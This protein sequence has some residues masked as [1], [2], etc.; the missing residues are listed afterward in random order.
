MLRFRRPELLLAFMAGLALFA[1]WETILG[2]QARN[3]SYQQEYQAK[4]NP[5]DGHA[6]AANKGGDGGEEHGHKT[7]SEPFVCGVAGIPT[8][9]R[10]FMNRNEG[11]F[12]ASFTLALVLVTAWLVWA[13]LKLWDAGENQLRFLRQSAAVQAR[14]MQASISA[15]EAG[16]S[17]AQDTAQRQLRAYVTVSG[18]ARTKDPGKLEGPGFAVLVDVQN[19]GQTPAY[20]LFQWADIEIREFPLKGPLRIYCSN[21]PTLGILAPHRKTMSFPSFKRSLTPLEE[22]DILSEGKAVYVY[23]EIAY[24]DAFGRKHLTQFRFRCTGQ[25]YALG[26]FKADGQGNNAT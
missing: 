12:V 5:I 2:Y 22:Q 6:P 9:A 25:G 14:D 23:G 13:T 21:T 15:A 8:A 10:Q 1:L 7:V 11:F 19:D 4:A 24:R 17:V 26:L 3:C 16:V 18:V 20:D